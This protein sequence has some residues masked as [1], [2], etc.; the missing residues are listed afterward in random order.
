M[1]SMFT[2]APLRPEPVYRHA[3]MRQFWAEWNVGQQTFA[4]ANSIVL[5]ATKLFIFDNFF[6]PFWALSIPLLLCPY[7]LR[8]SEERVTVLLLVIFVLMIAPLI[9]TQPHYAAAFAGV[10]YL[11]FLHSLMRLCSWRPWGKPIGFALGV[12]VVGLL[13]GQSLRFV[14]G[15]DLFSDGIALRNAAFGSARHAVVQVLEAQPGRD[16]VLVRY[17]GKHDPQNEWVYND[18]DID[19]SPVVWAREM[20]PEQD[21][22]FLE[23]FHDRRVWLLEPDISPQPV[24]YHRQ[25]QP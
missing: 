17:E 21:R 14:A 25:E 23:Y 20:G 11:R 24:P 7:D 1:A 15:R 19:A 13:L 3:I 4:R 6:F 18:A 10:F 5:L 16:L 22:P 2:M 8:D 9:A 12:V